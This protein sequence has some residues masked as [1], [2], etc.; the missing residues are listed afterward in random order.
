M[1][2]NGFGPSPSLLTS[3]RSEILLLFLS[4]FFLM[5]MAA[6]AKDDRGGGRNDLSGN[7]DDDDDREEAN[8]TSIW[9][10]STGV[11]SLAMAWAGKVWFAGILAVLWALFGLSGRL[12]KPLSVAEKKAME[13]NM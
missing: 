5:A 3:E 2:S 13:Y 10:I 4:V 1:I 8:A 11:A 12:M 7:G 9:M 6:K